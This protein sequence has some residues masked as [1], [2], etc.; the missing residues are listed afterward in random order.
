MYKRNNITFTTYNMTKLQ[1]Q[2]HTIIYC[3]RPAEGVETLSE[4]DALSWLQGGE[5][6]GTVCLCGA[7]DEVLVLRCQQIQVVPLSLFPLS[8]QKGTVEIMT[9][10][11]ITHCHDSLQTACV[12]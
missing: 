6:D 10:R 9:E 8:L 3:L 5:A 1:N 7:G 4:H 2:H 11:F 12:S